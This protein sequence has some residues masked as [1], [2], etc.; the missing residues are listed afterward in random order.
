MSRRRK[1][2]QGGPDRD[3]GRA[4]RRAIEA[5]RVGTLSMP[6]RGRI[7]EA[8]DPDRPPAPVRRRSDWLP[9]R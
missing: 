4:G 3:G 2:S 5:D 7:V 1:M 9:M 6:S 8:P